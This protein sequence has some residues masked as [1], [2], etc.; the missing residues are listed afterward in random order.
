MSV[1]KIMDI[2]YYIPNNLDGWS[3]HIFVFQMLYFFWQ[4]LWNPWPQGGKSLRTLFSLVYAKF[5]QGTFKKKKKKID[6][7]MQ[8]KGD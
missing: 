4:L 3:F 1:W 7:Y 5:H 2:E 8:T 6:V